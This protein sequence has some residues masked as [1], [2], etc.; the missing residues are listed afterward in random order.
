MSGAI[1]PFPQYVFMAWC[2]GT[3]FYL[4]YTANVMNKFKLF[5]QGARIIIRCQAAPPTSHS[6]TQDSYCSTAE[7]TEVI[8]PREVTV[9][10]DKVLYR[11]RHKVM[12][13]LSFVTSISCVLICYGSFSG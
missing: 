9:R 6:L 1:P 12:W 8:N 4:L 3:T 5:L 7:A 13:K 10:S 2:T 11:A